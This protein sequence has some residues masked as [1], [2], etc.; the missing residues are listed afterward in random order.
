MRRLDRYVATTVLS[1]IMLVLF[2]I[3]GLDA[4]TAFIDEAEDISESYGFAQIA[5]YVL[6]TLPD[7]FY[8]FVGPSALVGCMLGLGSLASSSELVVMRAAG[9]STARLTWIAMKPAFLIAAL[10]F[11]IGEY[12]APRS[13]QMA[14]TYKALAMEEEGGYSADSGLWNREGNTFV[15]FN[16]VEKEGIAHGL[17]IFQFDDKRQLES[18]LRASRAVFHGDHWVMENVVRTTFS[19]T[20]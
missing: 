8:E 18:A 17:L 9:V 7:R 12:V 14:Q 13:E 1:A 19:I 11:L 4:V 10:G 3:V 5:W 2:V 20:Q 16:A 15:S 6:L